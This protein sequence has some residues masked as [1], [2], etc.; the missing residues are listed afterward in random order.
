LHPFLLPYVLT[1]GYAVAPNP[2]VE[3]TSTTVILIPTPAPPAAAPAAVARVRPVAPVAP[4]APLL[5]KAFYVIPRCYAGDAPPRQDLL[6]PG[7]STAN[8]RTI[9]PAAGRP[10]LEQEREIPKDSALVTLRGCAR[11]RAFV[12]APRSEDSPGT[13][14]IAP[15]R[16]F[17]LSGSKSILQD[18]RKR[19]R[20]M[21]EITG[22]VRKSDISGPGGIS[23][24]GGRV[25]IGGGPP[26][27]Q[28]GAARLDSGYN[29]AVIDVE[30]WRSLL[31]P[32]PSR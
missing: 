21:V 1:P 19:E 8:L 6:P 20:M 15:G 28:T 24:G 16:R 13:L 17:R 4:S 18:I 27:S 5:E 26:Q 14:E 12:V 29:Q 10:F 22:L 7:C 31:E 3:R 32:C 23:L 9:L 2:P 30:S 25:R 11:D